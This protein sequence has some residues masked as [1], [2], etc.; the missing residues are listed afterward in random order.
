MA[1]PYEYTPNQPTI[2]SRIAGQFRAA[3]SRLGLD[4]EGLFKDDDE[5]KATLQGDF[6]PNLQMET[7]TRGRG[8][9]AT[10]KP[11]QK[12]PVTTTFS[13]GMDS[14]GGASIVNN[15]NPVNNNTVTTGG[16]GGGGGGGFVLPEEQKKIYQG[17]AGGIIADRF[18][19]QYGGTGFGMGDLQRAIDD[20]YDVDSIRTYLK[21]FSGQIGPKAAEALGIQPRGFM[22]T[23]ARAAQLE[24]DGTNIGLAGVQRMAQTLGI[25]QE[26]AAR[27]A[28][29]SGI[30]LGQK[31]AALL[32]GGNKV[33]TRGGGGGGGNAGRTVQSV[34]AN[35]ATAY[36]S[37]GSIGLQ[38]LQNTAAAQGIS[39]QAAKQQAINAGLNL[40][41]KAQRV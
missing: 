16:G 8:Y 25:S 3:G 31:A 37:G 20:D 24:G 40:G 9:G 18:Q 2:D 36:S 33:D 35:P 6:A 13:L 7:T 14:G 27:Q 5:G 21:G 32:G 30:N 10:M 11:Q 41:E 34:A 1:S 23:A 38:G 22:K 28:R 29:A 12:D 39:L 26:E 15:F 17:M 19:K 4:L